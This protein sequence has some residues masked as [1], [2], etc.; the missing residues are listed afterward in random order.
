MCE[1]CRLQFFFNAAIINQKDARRSGAQAE[2]GFPR[3]RGAPVFIFLE[4]GASCRKAGKGW[5]T[6]VGP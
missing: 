1:I 6:E 3:E 2:G 4:A 5:Y